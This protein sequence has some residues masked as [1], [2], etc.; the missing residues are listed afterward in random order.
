MHI[1]TFIFESNLSSN[2]YFHS[3]SFNN[4]HRE[5]GNDEINVVLNG[6]N[7][8]GHLT[9]DPNIFRFPLRLGEKSFMTNMR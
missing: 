1:T 6:D 3:I 9:R 4:F 8:A 2:L 7:P 5:L